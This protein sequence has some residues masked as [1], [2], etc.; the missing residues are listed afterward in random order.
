MAYTLLGQDFTPPDLRAKVTGQAKYAEDF[1]ADG[2]LFT[3][4]LLSPMPHARVVYIDKEGA[5]AL[6]G[7][8]WTYAII[9]ATVSTVLPLF[10]QAEA[11]RR[12]GATEFAL[13]GA[14]SPVSV[15]VMSALGLGEPFGPR[16]MAG[17][18]LVIGGVLLVSL[19]KG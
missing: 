17:A 5:L 11:L 9:L 4:L 19:K 2:M 6:P 3:K 14:V 12:I 15:A 7:S 13:V 8:V 10:L 1:R 18:V 16:Q